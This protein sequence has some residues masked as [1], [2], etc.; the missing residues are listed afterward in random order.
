LSRLNILCTG[1]VEQYYTKMK[2]YPLFT[3]HI[4]RPNYLFSNALDFIEA[5]SSTQ[6][7]VTAVKYFFARVRWND[8]LLTWQFTYHLFSRLR[9]FTEAKKLATE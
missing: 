5:E 4:F 2:F 9:E 1:L 3:V 8:T 7:S 6:Q